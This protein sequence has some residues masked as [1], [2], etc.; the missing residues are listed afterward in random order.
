MLA[1]SPSAPGSNRSPVHQPGDRAFGRLGGYWPPRIPARV[2][3]VTDLPDVL[4]AAT[5]P[6][7]G[8]PYVA[9]GASDTAE[10]LAAIRGWNP[11]LV[12]V[13]MALIQTEMRE[14]QY[15]ARLGLPV[16][17]VTRRTDPVGI[18]GA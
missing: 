15:L 1:E 3:V 9:H 2:L 14:E 17:A 10:M 13:D 6:L 11:H 5:H 8:G 12:I 16:I 4:K 18:V 7:T